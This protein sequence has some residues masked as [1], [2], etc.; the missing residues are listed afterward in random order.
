MT[1]VKITIPF[2]LNF[3]FMVNLICQPY[4]YNP[5][6]ILDARKIISDAPAIGLKK[7]EEKVNPI[8]LIHLDA[9]FSSTLIGLEFKSGFLEKHYSNK[10]VYFYKLPS[11]T[12]VLA[13]EHNDKEA[14]E[15]L[16]EYYQQIPKFIKS[17]TIYVIYNNLDNFLKVLVKSKNPNIQ[18]RLLQDYK[19]WSELAKISKTKSYLSIEERREKYRNISLDEML[20]FNEDDLYVD[21]SYIA[22]QLAGAL[23][24]LKVKGFDNEL[25]ENLKKQQANPYASRYT[26]RVYSFTPNPNHTNEHIK[27]VP[28]TEL[29]KNFDKDSQKIEKF[30]FKNVD[31]CCGAKITNIIYDD[32]KA[33]INVSR[34]NGSDDF[35]LKINSDNTITI[36]PISMIMEQPVFQ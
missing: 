29:I 22:L 17:D 3:V 7:L 8:T 28:N 27:V 9:S 31:N 21:C 26:F 6:Q 23:N 14:Q 33:Y 5:V 20:K 24:Y 10:N 30:L 35:L 19:E 11:Y 16:F 1:K 32:T 13:N 15:K 12:F 4:K 2:L 34:N 36:E 25:L 18:K